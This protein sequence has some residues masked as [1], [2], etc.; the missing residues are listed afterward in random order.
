MATVVNQFRFLCQVQWYLKN[1][2]SFGDLTASNSDG[3]ST[4][5][6][7]VNGVSAGQVDQV[8]LYR[9]LLAGGAALVLDLQGTLLDP[10]AVPFLP[11]R[12]KG[13]YCRHLATAGHTSSG[14]LVGSAASNS[15][16]A[17][18]VPVKRGGA[19]QLFDPT[20]AGLAPVAAGTADQFRVVNADGANSAEVFL[21]LVGTSA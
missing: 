7:F 18:Q 5:G 15:V 11:A 8:Y 14:L 6:T 1:P 12:L 10:V 17:W 20:A 4:E 9:G 3:V 16:V 13:V 2:S 19:F 21:A